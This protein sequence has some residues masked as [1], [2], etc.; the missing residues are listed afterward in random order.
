[1]YPYDG[2]LR[3]VVPDNIL[4]LRTVDKNYQRKSFNKI[5]KGKVLDLGSKILL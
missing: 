2:R 1:M 4:V 3:R 5:R